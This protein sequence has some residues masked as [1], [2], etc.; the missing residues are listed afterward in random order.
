MAKDDRP[1][2]NFS[3]LWRLATD[4]E[5]RGAELEA[6]RRLGTEDADEDEE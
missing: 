5:F 4:K 2:G 3:M 1:R 6:G